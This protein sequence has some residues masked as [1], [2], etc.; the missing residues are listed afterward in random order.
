MT[1]Y[2]IRITPKAS[3]DIEETHSYIAYELFEPITADKYTAGIYEA[4]KKLSI[5]SGSIA[6]SQREYIQ[7]NYGPGARTVIYKKMTIVY[8][9]I[10]NIILIRRVTAGGLVL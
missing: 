3:Q 1:K 5:Y 4:I 6:V 10:D 9:I 7:R 8:N 2:N